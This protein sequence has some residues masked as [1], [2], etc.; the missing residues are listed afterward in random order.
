MMLEGVGFEIVD[1]GTDISP[2]SFVSAVKEYTPDLVGMS[3]LLTTTM[4][5]IGKTIEALEE[6]S[7][8]EQVKIII[9]GAPITQE[10][11]DKVG[12]DGFATDAGSASRVV[13]SL[14]GIT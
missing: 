3:A 11:A 12:A 2:E 8:R 9:G 14:L 10:F 6:A 5:S 4:L 7:V 1:L 13:K